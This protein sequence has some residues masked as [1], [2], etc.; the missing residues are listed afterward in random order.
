MALRDLAAAAAAAAA[1]LTCGS[2]A[3]SADELP[4][5]KA[6]LFESK[7]VASRGAVPEMAFKQCMD[8]K[9]DIEALMKSTGGVCDLKWRRAGS[10]LAS[11]DN[12]AA[13]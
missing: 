10:A 6:G 11:P 12:S 2:G 3:A 4:T 7:M 8:G 9:I 13:T 5:L 1:F